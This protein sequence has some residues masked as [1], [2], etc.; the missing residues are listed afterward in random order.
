MASPRATKDWIKAVAGYLNL[1][2]SDLAVKS[3]L[4]P[5]TVTRYINDNTGKLT[6]QD[7]TLDAISRYSGVAKNV[8]PGQ[9][10]LPGH[11]ESEAIPYDA[12]RDEALPEWVEAAIGAIKGDRNGIE[13]WIVKSWSLDLMGI[14][15][16]DVLVID[17]NRRPKGGDIVIARITDLVTGA[18]ET[19]L[20]RYDPP[21]IMTHSAKSGSTRPETV[22][23]ERVIIVGVRAG[24]IRP[25]H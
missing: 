22:D 11:G 20:R 3:G 14:V 1:S 4:S 23:D 18:A 24:L 6:V 8:M 12:V 5:S 25:Y 9:R 10:G 16:G 7:R 13:P 17:Q 2:L 21:F 19:V 15:P